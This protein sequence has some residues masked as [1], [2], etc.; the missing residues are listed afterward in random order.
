MLYYAKLFIYI[1]IVICKIYSYLL[2]CLKVFRVVSGSLFGQ[3][4]PVAGLFYKIGSLFGQTSPVSGL[5]CNNG[6]IFGQISPV[7]GLFCH[8]GLLFG[9]ISPIARLFCNIGSLFGQISAVAGLFCNY[10]QVHFLDSFLLLQDYFVN[11]FII[12]V[13]FSGC[14]IIL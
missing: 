6:S 4:S 3:I 14:R 7:G 11:R 5:F 2:C 13:D 9:Q 8:I 10:I 1:H 12:W